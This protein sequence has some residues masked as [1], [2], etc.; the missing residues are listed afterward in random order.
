MVQRKPNSFHLYYLNDNFSQEDIFLYWYG[1]L[2]G[3]VHVNRTCTEVVR[4]WRQFQ[5]STPSG[6]GI[7][8]ESVSFLQSGETLK[9]RTMDKTLENTF[10]SGINTKLPTCDDRGVF[11]DDDDVYRKHK[12][13]TVDRSLVGGG[14]TV[15]W[16][17]S[18][19]DTFYMTQ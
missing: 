17:E 10:K 7:L 19:Y 9:N 2:S 6:C 4:M 14:S 8:P 13:P 1:Y 3:N 11:T 18:V 16:A 15:I 12:E 5:G